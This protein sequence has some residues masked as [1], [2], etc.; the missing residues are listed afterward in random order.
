MLGA[1]DHTTILHG[2]KQHEARMGIPPKVSEMT[3]DKPP[4]NPFKHKAEKQSGITGITWAKASGTWQVRI[5][6]NGRVRRF[7]TWETLEEAIEA[8]KYALMELEDEANVK[9]T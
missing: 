2:I 5:Q 1:A 6:I 7:G 3:G 4:I 8:K 9:G